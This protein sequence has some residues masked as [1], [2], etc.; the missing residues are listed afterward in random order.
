MPMR[1]NLV[2]D[3]TDVDLEAILVAAAPSSSQIVLLHGWGGSAETM[4]PP[5][6]QFAELGY[7]ALCVSMRGWGQSG[8]EDDCGLKQPAD[9]A[10]VLAWLRA[11]VPQT[12]RI[13]LFGISQGGQVALLAAARGVDIAAVAAWAPVTDVASWRATTEYPGIP[14]YIDAVC[15]D[16]DLAARSPMSVV[17]DLRVPLLLVHGD[18]DTRVPTAQSR[19]LHAAVAAAGGSSRLEEL[20]GVGHQRGPAGN[21]Q[22]FDVTTDFFATHLKQD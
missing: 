11:N 8:G 19:A 9:V 1:T 6:M 4:V 14:E 18:A 7:G 12:R 22:A 2:I 13:G 16:G 17:A 21:T 15:A 3:G 5:A 20:P 10:A